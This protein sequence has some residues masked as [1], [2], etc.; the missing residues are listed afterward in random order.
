[1]TIEVIGALAV[2]AGF[3]GL[4]RGPV[5]A[6]WVLALSTLLGA[7][8]A[9]KLPALGDASVPPALVLTGFFALCVVL[10]TRMRVAAIESLTTP[11]PGFWILLFSVYAV[12]SAYFMPRLFQ[13]LTYAYS[14][15]RNDAGIGI[16]SL[17]LRPRAS[18]ATQAAY[19]VANLVCFMGVWALMVRGEAKAITNALLASAAALLFFAVADVVTHYTGTAFLLSWLRNA[20]YRM[21][22]AGEIGGL[23]RIVG[24]FTEAGAYSYAAL[25][26]Y[27]FSLSLWLDGFSTRLTGALSLLLAVSLLLSTSTTAYGSFAIFT[28][29][30]LFGAL[31]KLGRCQATKRDCGYLAIVSLIPVL[32]LVVVMFMPSVWSAL[33]GLFDATVSNKLASQSGIERM[34]WNH[35][36]LQNF[37]DTSGFGAGLGSVRS[38]SFVVALLANLGVLGLILF[39]VTLA[40]AFSTGRLVSFED[41]VA[42]A[43]F[44]ACIALTG[45]ACISAAGVDLGLVFAIFF[46]LAASGWKL[47]ARVA[48]EQAESSALVGAHHFK[49]QGA[50]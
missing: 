2:L 23:K 41:V 8:A 42:R 25:G 7:A 6:F 9:F 36:A 29:L 11:G 1:M 21:L 48:P 38:S 16:V 24:T 19:L 18:N 30:M 22:E 40:S 20:N 5:A 39:V 49:L 45:A 32:L 28:L 3:W 47:R 37:Q 15:A 34:R 50:Q 33:T 44:R 35:Y 27:A 4:W 17:P 10:R 13:G 12:V 14:L 26:F 43:G 46:A 31:L